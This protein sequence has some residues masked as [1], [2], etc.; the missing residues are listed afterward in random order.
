M[1]TALTLVN[2]AAG[3]G[4]TLLAADWAGGLQ[5]PVA[6]LTAEAGDEGPGV[7]WSYVL[8]SL[9]R[10]SEPVGTA[11]GA[12]VRADRVE[13]RLLMALA[14]E[15]SNRSQPVVLVIDEI[16][17]AASGEIAEQLDFLLHHAGAGLR[18][19]LVSRAEP[20]LPLHAYRAKDELTEIRAAELAFTR[21]EAAALMETQGLC[22][23]GAAVDSL[24]E[25]TG[26]WATGLRLCALAASQ[27]ADPELYLKE[28]EAER[29]TIADYLLAEVLQG[30]SEEA[31]D[32]LLRVSVLTRFRPELA[33]ALTGRVDAGPL[34][35]GLHRENAFVE[36]L[37]HS[38]YRLHPLFK[39]IL[40]AHLRVRLPGLEPELH[41]RAARWMRHNGSLAETLGHGVAAGDWQFAADT[42]VDE[43]A[44][45]Q[46]CTGLQSEPLVRLFSEMPPATTGV[47]PEL[48][49]ATLGLAR[50]DIPRG[51]A[52]LRRARQQ[53]LD[54]QANGTAAARLG[55]VLLET[56]AARLTGA[57]GWAE[58]AAKAAER[59]R[60]EVPA[61]ILDEHPELTALLHTHLGAARLWAGR[62]KD[63]RVA[64]A[65]VAEMADEA[66]VRLLQEESWDHL[67]LIDYLNGW[68]KRAEHKV[69]ARTTEP[70]GSSLP[71]PSSTGLGRL[72]LAS[73]AIDRDEL[74]QA[75]ALL[76][77]AVR[78]P[79]AARDPVAAAVQGVVRARLSL[80]TGRPAAAAAEATV[81]DTDVAS[82]WADSH[83]AL[84]VA[85][86]RLA[87][88]RL[89][90]AVAVL[91]GVSRDYPLCAVGAARILLAAG[92]RDAAVD[93]VDDITSDGRA[94]PAVTVRTALVRACAAAQ[95]G[96]A[97]GARRLVER[98]LLDARRDRLRRPF[99]DARA[100]IWPLLT[101]PA[102]RE[103]AAG[104]LI[105]TGQGGG[106]GTVGDPGLAPLA[107][108]ELSERELDVLRRLA[109]AMSTGEIAA[110][111]CVSVNTVKTHL[112]GV[113]RKL[114]V[115]RRGEAVRRARELQLL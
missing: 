73:V 58:E 97:A 46:L 4:K 64:F 90:E 80:L 59:L 14:A 101:A 106:E 103:L 40:R 27:S 37:G 36:H 24:V 21:E 68:L 55:C 44:V 99:L 7:F 111:L 100:C 48:I 70:E 23:P 94:G 1:D 105:P 92:R 15:L 104:W 81:V 19:V 30:R 86:A 45:G 110:D 57:P 89:Q 67:A 41:R 63:A 2:G 54:G 112:R 6:W 71:S 18:L 115:N 52:H 88:G 3:A 113:Y 65:A 49:R 82:S 93:L 29:S 60:H 39:E 25:R 78:L 96:D 26:G 109:L 98:A 43:L 72:V 16:D 50:Y 107:V 34:L 33:D 61:R 13:R 74:D 75:Q 77:E 38:W 62:L 11:V 76:A 9:R 83:K 17:R 87:E 69:L 31:Q 35:F 53:L 102:L 47:A 10:C 85:A 20:L 84:V 66:P 114:A 79:A 32:L 5:L 56:V 91:D 22:L 108:A 51:L 28:F 42:L 95:A 8:H 12:P